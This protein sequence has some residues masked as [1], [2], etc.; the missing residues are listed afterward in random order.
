MGFWLQLNMIT[1]GGD[2]LSASCSSESY[3]MLENN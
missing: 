2:I 3:P 1:K